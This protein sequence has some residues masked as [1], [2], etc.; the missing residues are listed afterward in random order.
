MKD[1]LVELFDKKGLDSKVQEIL[2]SWKQE[3]PVE[4][5]HLKGWFEIQYENLF[6]NLEGIFEDDDI[7]LTLKYRYLELKA[8]WFQLNNKIQYSL[9]NGEIDEALNYKASLL[10]LLINQFEKVLPS[11]NIQSIKKLLK[12]QLESENPD[13]FIHVDMEKQLIDLYHDKEMLHKY[14]GLSS[15]L[16]I[17]KK[18]EDLTDKLKD[19]EEKL[20]DLNDESIEIRFEDEKMVIYGPQKVFVNKKKK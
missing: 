19:A 18:I 13:Q 8:K 14:L 1:N 16:T 5:D 6:Y 17:I 9:L 4:I 15:P 10:S 11:E 12:E 7:Q 3:D 2:G 20:K